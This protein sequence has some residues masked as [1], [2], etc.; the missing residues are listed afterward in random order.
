MM[1]LGFER[2][3]V[4]GVRAGDALRDVNAVTRFHILDAVADGLD[5]ASAVGTGCVRERGLYS[6]G[7]SAHVGVVGIHT[8]GMNADEDL[9][10][11]W[12]G[13]GNFFVLQHFRRAELM[14][15]DGL[16]DDSPF[17]VSRNA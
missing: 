5:N 9:A 12:L 11:G 2:E 4:F 8:G 14:D 3:S 6:V 16:H 7:A 10:R 13:R 15:N 17:V 1:R